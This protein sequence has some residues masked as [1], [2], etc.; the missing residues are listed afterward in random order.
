MTAQIFIA[1]GCAVLAL[2]LGV[3]WQQEDRLQ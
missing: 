3:R 1:L 2:A